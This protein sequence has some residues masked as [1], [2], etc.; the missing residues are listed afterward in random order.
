MNTLAPNGG[1]VEA[2]AFAR[3]GLGMG[4]AIG[5]SPLSAPLMTL[6][7]GGDVGLVGV[8]PTLIMTGL[9]GWGAT[10]VADRLVYRGVR[11]CGLSLGE[12]SAESMMLAH[13]F[14]LAGFVGVALLLAEDVEEAVGEGGERGGQCQVGSSCKFNIELVC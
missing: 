13:G 1:R 12:D 11:D 14:E 7:P 8:R 5:E 4:D 10:G 2:A 6:S 3:Y 9:I